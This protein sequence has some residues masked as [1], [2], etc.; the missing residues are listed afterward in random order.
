MSLTDN[1]VFVVDRSEFGN[2]TRPFL[3]IEGS[4]VVVADSGVSAGY[5]GRP[6]L[7]AVVY[8]TTGKNLLDKSFPLPLDF[9]IVGIQIMTALGISIETQT[10]MFENFMTN[11]TAT[12]RAGFIAAFE[13]VDPNDSAAVAAFVNQMLTLLT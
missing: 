13:A 8:T 6:A 3:G 5:A 11:Y 10:T 9:R 7:E 2:T 1:R 4:K 12:Q